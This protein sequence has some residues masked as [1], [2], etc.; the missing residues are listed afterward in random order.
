MTWSSRHIPM[1]IGRLEVRLVGHSARRK[2]L[3]DH[4]GFQHWRWEY[5]NGSLRFWFLLILFQ[6][7]LLRWDHNQ[8]YGEIQICQRVWTRHFKP[9]PSG[10]SESANK[11]TQLLHLR[12]LFPVCLTHLHIR[13][14]DLI[15]GHRYRPYSRWSRDPLIISDWFS[16]E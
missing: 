7:L 15:R 14:W 13:R 2:I 16:N 9:S 10:K 12:P 3:G 8:S 4:D 1:T 5:L 6:C 11:H